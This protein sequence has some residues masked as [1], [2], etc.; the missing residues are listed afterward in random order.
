MISETPRVRQMLLGLAGRR[1]TPTVN[2]VGELLECTVTLGS[3]VSVRGP[4]AAIL[5]VILRATVR[6][7]SLGRQLLVAFGVGRLS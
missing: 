6:M 7:S 2:P 3:R 4:Y 1:Q 5:I